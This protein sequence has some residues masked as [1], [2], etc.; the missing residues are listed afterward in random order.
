ML[1]LCGE[2]IRIHQDHLAD[3]NIKGVWNCNRAVGGFEITVNINVS[4][5][6]FAI[7]S[8]ADFIQAWRSPAYRFSD[9]LSFREVAWI[10][11]G[12]RNVMMIQTLLELSRG[13]SFIFV[14]R[15][16]SRVRKPSAAYRTSRIFV[17]GSEPMSMGLEATWM[18]TSAASSYSAIEWMFTSG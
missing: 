8:R 11:L 16:T 6:R 14:H 10:K 18:I 5:P 4:V 12:L 13:N 7:W 1:G 3:I 15:S 17:F 2:V 9:N